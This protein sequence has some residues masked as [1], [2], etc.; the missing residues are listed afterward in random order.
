M[1]VVNRRLAISKYNDSKL[2]D[3]AEM[4]VQKRRQR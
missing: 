2:K 1:G 4:I 3:K